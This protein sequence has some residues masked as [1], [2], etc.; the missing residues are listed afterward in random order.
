MDF[1]LQGKGGGGNLKPNQ[2]LKGYSFTNDDG[3]Q[4]GS[5]DPNL[6]P[7]NILNGKNIF[8]V[9]GTVKPAPAP[10][11]IPPQGFTRYLVG[12]T[13]KYVLAYTNESS[14]NINNPIIYYKDNGALYAHYNKMNTYSNYVLFCHDGFWYYKDSMFYKYSYENILLQSM[15]Y[16]SSAYQKLFRENTAVGNSDYFYT[17]KMSFNASN[18]VLG[19]VW[20]IDFGRPI[21]NGIK[22]QCY[23]Y[24]PSET[25]TPLRGKEGPI[26]SDTKKM[27]TYELPLE[28]Y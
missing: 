2:A 22:R 12:V 16:V 11:P 13:D 4:V 27:N 10:L 6:I 7:E 17:N 8:G 15:P 3:P 28:I 23:L 21:M 14:T 9:T 18:F 26:E 19:S 25:L 20:Y 5:G 1:I 24:S